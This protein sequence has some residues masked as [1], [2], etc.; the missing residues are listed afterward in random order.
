MTRIINKIVLITILLF[1]GSG[2]AN[3]QYSIYETIDPDKVE[4]SFSDFGKMWTFD[5]IPLDYLEAEYG[6]R[7]TQEWIEHIQ[8]S[9]LQFANGC[10]AAFLSEDGLIM[11]NHHCGRDRLIDIQREGEDLLKDGFYAAT[12][13]EER[14]IPDM[15]VDQLI[16]IEDVTKEIQ[17][18]MDAVSSNDEKIAGRDAKI[19]ELTAKY[20][21][22][23]GLAC[24]VVTLYNGRKYSMYGYKR[25]ND[26]RLVMS[27][28]FQIAATGWDWDNFT[29]PRYELDFAFYRAYD[30]NGKPAKIEHHFGWSKEGAK[31]DELIFT[32]G[33]PGRTNRL[34]SMA[35]LT[36]MRDKRYS[37]LLTMFNEI[38]KVY[39][40]LFIKYTD[41][42]SELLNRVMGFG[43]GRKSFAGSLLGLRDSYMMAKKKDFEKKLIA[44]VKADPEL[45]K[46][47]GHLW[48]SLKIAVDELIANADETA[49][50]TVPGFLRSV[51]LDIARDIIKYADQ[52]KLNEDE[53]EDAYKKDKLED[54]IKDIVAKIELDEYQTELNFKL[55]R[56]HVNYIST[57]LGDDNL[58]VKALFNGMT[59]EDGAKYVL[60]KS[61]LTSKEGIEMMLEKSPDEILNSEDPFI[62]F[63]SQTRDKL[64]KLTERNRE[65]QNTIDVNNQLLGQAVAAV[66]GDKI[67]PDATGTLRI[68]DGVI[69]GYEY[70]GTLAPGKVSYYGL[71]D[72]WASFNKK[73]YPWGL[74]PRWQNP[75]ADFDLETSIG[76]ASTNDIVGGNS[77]SSLINTKGEVVGLAHDGNLES[78][79][80]Y[81][82]FIPENNR[83]VSTDAVGLIQALKYI[84]KTDRLTDEIL[85]G[86]LGSHND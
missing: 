8:K 40:E 4:F 13:E 49:A 55:V 71:Y 46:K 20:N 43:N 56:A 37:N 62:Y 72:R 83:C 66:Y 76:F 58:F 12:L 79:A 42:E 38:Y 33:R 11:T 60:G 57:V 14:N 36:Y 35:E 50:Y 64:I 28:D 27:P 34:Y 41:R 52:M 16:L 63:Y 73:L 81:F 21:E 32:V 67:S 17:D 59:D 44:A 86:K 78:L 75:P 39:Y 2:I 84:Y 19:D 68:S 6:F 7:P 70:N 31:E 74:H 48:E 61:A 15:F 30:E 26:I 65:I 22:E 29:Y 23:T 1:C 77:G 3:A 18:A 51:Y 10:S 82:I 69:K 5:S 24:S 80:G 85:N 53:R 54:T 45:T 47:Y 9:G 25:Y